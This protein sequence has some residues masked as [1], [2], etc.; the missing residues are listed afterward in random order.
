MAKFARTGCLCLG[1]AFAL[2]AIWLGVPARS[3]AGASAVATV[4]EP[5]IPT[6]IP[7]HT[8]RD[9]TGT[10]QQPVAAP[11]SETTLPGLYSV[12]Q[13]I[14]LG[15]PLPTFPE[16]IARELSPGWYLDW[17]VNLHAL[18]LPDL[19]YA[20][21]VRLSGSSYRPD[22]ETIRQAAMARPGALWLIG[23]EPDVRWQDNVLPDDYARLYHQLYHFLK[24]VDPSCQ[25]AIGGISQVTP[26]RLRYLEAILDAY[27]RLYG[28]PMPVD[29]WNIHAFI[30]REEAD[31]WG[32]GIP[33][34]FDEPRGQLYEVA[35]HDNLSIFAN[36]LVTF[37]R[38][39]KT[40]GE[41]DKPLIVSEY[42]ILMPEDYGFPPERVQRF[43]VES[44][45]YMH[46]ARD[47]TIGYAP[48]GDRLVQRWCWFSLSYAQYPTGDLIQLPSGEL[49]PL[50]E[51]FASY[52]S[53]HSDNATDQ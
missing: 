42:G 17:R 16:Q 10:P 12:R 13:R 32:V 38:W 11:A 6:A 20:P 36:Q 28:A 31:S 14:G 24:G 25:V 5:L 35:D 39:M 40:R 33:P 45:D 15:V 34:G 22:L 37:R 18:Q 26:L 8:V 52:I 2:S 7:T 27:Q 23:N 50:G 9:G 47:S 41:Q 48:D 51:T 43:M 4:T 53:A 46:N 29:V 44:F 49:T 3:P 21:M 19:E 30:L 1:V